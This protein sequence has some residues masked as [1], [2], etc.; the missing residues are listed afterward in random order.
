SGQAET[1]ADA[2]G[3]QNGGTPPPSQTPPPSTPQPRTP[4]EPSNPTASPWGKE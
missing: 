3:G 4:T 1:A 2:A